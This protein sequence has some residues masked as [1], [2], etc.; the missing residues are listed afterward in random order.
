M[1]KSLESL[2]DMYT[3]PFK[4]VVLLSIIGKQHCNTLF[5]TLEFGAFDILFSLLIHGWLPC[6]WL[7][8]VWRSAQART[9]R[10]ATSA[11][12]LKKEKESGRMELN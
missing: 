10:Q 8:E 6:F 1:Q 4:A 2:R 7:S 5:F 9:R 12:K 3:L 11:K